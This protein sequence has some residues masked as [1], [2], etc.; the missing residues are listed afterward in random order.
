MNKDDARL[1]LLAEMVLA[2]G[3]MHM[4]STKG[5]LSLLDSLESRVQMHGELLRMPDCDEKGKLI[6]RMGELEDKMVSGKKPLRVKLQ[7]AIAKVESLHEQI[8][9]EIASWK[10]SSSEPPE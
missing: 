9:A 4:D 5:F 10:S 2:H 3:E 7:D 8:G 1:H 6:T